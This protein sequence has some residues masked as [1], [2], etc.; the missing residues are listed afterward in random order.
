MG[1]GAVAKG[2]N[3]MANYLMYFLVV[4]VVALA[5]W[6]QKTKDAASA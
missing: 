4:L 5:V 2:N 3:E 1:Q 6:Y